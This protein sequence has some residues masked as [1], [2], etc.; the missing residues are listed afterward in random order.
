MQS[1]LCAITPPHCPYF[2]T[3]LHQL[4]YHNTKRDS[5]PIWLL[6]STLARAVL[7]LPRES[8]CWLWA[9]TEYKRQKYAREG[10]GQSL[11]IRDPSRARDYRPPGTK[12]WG[13]DLIPFGN[14]SLAWH[15]IPAFPGT[16]HRVWRSEPEFLLPCK[17]GAGRPSSSGAR[18]SPPPSPP[19]QAPCPHASSSSPPTSQLTETRRNVFSWGARSSRKGKVPL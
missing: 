14:P 18:S 19:P 2:W 8:L 12:P 11:G 6:C 4:G 5:E 15:A 7:E 1:I 13:S 3:L 10:E 9:E 17:C 16:A